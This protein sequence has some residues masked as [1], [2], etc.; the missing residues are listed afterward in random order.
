MS[1][2]MAIRSHTRKG[3]AARQIIF[4]LSTHWLPNK[5]DEASLFGVFSN[6]AENQQQEC[7]G[8]FSD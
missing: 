3:A 8:Y 4:I 1:S 2:I 7:N 5:L 6:L